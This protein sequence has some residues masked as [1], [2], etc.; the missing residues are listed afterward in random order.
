MLNEIK[1]SLNQGYSE[2]NKINGYNYKLKCRNKHGG[3]VAII[4]KESLIVEEIS[5][6]IKDLEI[7]GLSIKCNNQKC[8]IFSIYNPPQSNLNIELFKYI[9]ST[10]KNYLIIG[11]LNAKIGHLGNFGRDSL[12]Y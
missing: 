2:L 8:F 4:Y 10:Y 1:C 7:I 12:F 5:L 9:D 6:P 3:G 11:D